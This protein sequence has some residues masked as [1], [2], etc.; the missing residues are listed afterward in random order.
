MFSS[1]IC[2]PQSDGKLQERP[3]KGRLAQREME[4][5]WKS[6]AEI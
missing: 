4:L 1:L 6:Q 3:K 2:H 5:P